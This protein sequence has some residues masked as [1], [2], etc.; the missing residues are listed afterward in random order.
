LASFCP[1]EQLLPEVTVSVNVVECDPDDAVPVIVTAYVPAGVELDVP[2]D[3]L[4][5]EPAATDVG[6]NVAVVPVGNPL[7]LSET[8]CDEP[9]VTAVE[10]VA[11]AALPAVTLLELG[12]TES[13]KSFAGALVTVSDNVVECVAVVPVPV[14]V[15]E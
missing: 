2:S 11:V 6:V 3:R 5:E 10:T 4:E 1:A 8:V 7:A 13:E 15:T 12:A 9:A 14:I